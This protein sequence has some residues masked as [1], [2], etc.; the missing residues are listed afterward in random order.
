MDWD[1]VRS[2]PREAPAP[3]FHDRVVWRVVK[4]TRWTEARIRQVP[5]GRELRFVVGGAGRED[6]LMHSNVF[7]EAEALAA[8]AT[9]IRQTFEAKGWAQVPETPSA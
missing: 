7:R 5:H 3:T 1:K 2:A 8:Y 9:G 4:D 6:T